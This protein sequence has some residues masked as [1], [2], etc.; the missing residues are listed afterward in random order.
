MKQLLLAQ[1]RSTF[2]HADWF[3]PFQTAI[4][5][6]SE[7]QAFEK[8]DAAGHSI[9]NLVQHLI[10]WNE[11]YLNRLKGISGQE[12]VKDNAATFEL[13]G[14]ISWKELEEK[15]NRLFHAWE[16][17]LEHVEEKTLHSEMTG[18]PWPDIIG[19][20]CLHN[21]YHTGQILTLRKMQGN[22]NSSKG[23]S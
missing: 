17:A 5:G 2:N 3:V 23:V 12:A 1:F 22:W 8:K 6:L 9:A 19:Q 20:I 11:R 4:E 15:A 21:A 7:E 14:S 13:P 16:T 10:F 18:I